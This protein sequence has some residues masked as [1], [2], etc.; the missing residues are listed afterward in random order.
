[1][2]SSAASMPFIKNLASSDRKIRTAALDSLKGF[3]TAKYAASANVPLT[4]HD[5]QKLWAGLFYA[6]WM[7]DRAPAQQRLCDEL[8]GLPKAVKL[9][10]AAVAAWL[11]A[12]W[13][14]M[15]RE[16]TTGI[17]VLR[18][19][20]FMLLVRR[21]LGAQIAWMAGE[22][23]KEKKETTADKK[24]SNTSKKSSKTAADSAARTLGLEILAEWPLNIDG[25][26]AVEPVPSA[27]GEAD[28]GDEE[29]SER[30]RK[31]SRKAV[32]TMH[33]PVGLTMHVVDI[34][35][36]EAEKQGLLATSESS[37]EQGAL[38]TSSLAHAMNELVVKLAAKTTA[39]AV[40]QRTREALTDDRLPWNRSAAEGQADGDGDDDKGDKA[41]GGWDGFTD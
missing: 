32:P 27:S 40:R 23:I 4:F 1:M 38:D 26:A 39:P 16:W 12:F 14:T 20:K 37:E 15:A 19:E 24:S 22:E 17:D 31:K 36:D 18:M 25:E 7:A 28:E 33:I 6:L 5:A 41:N 11:R 30:P 2:T 3:L 21:V 9:P 8:A 10:D 29:V 34:W 13:A 35:V